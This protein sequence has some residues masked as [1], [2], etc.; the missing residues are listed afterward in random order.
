MVK[1]YVAGLAA[2]LILAMPARAATVAVGPQYGSTHV[3]VAPDRLDAFVTSFI[4][5]FGGHASK[6]AT[7]TVTPAP[8][9]AV[10]RFVATPIGLL[11]VFAYTTPIPYP[12]GEERTGY[13]VTDMDAAVTAAREAGAE[14][15]VA[16]FAD[17]I[18]RDAIIRWPG[19]VEMQLYWHTTAPSA[20]PLAA[21]PDNRVYVSPDRADVFVRDFAQFSG[22][23][24]TDDDHAAPGVEIG[25]PAETYRRIRLTSAFGDMT[26][27]VTEG[28]LPWPYGREVTGYQAA[29]LSATLSK[30][31]A[32]GVDILAGPYSGGGRDAAMVR[33][34]GGYIAEIH[35][36]R[37]R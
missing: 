34:P 4:A 8:S 14:I 21:V 10:G 6:P 33:F 32:A 3:Y 27:L 18:G 11:S 17:A 16:P 1:R 28:H 9:S 24:V 36:V 15:V 12:F 37:P 20:P 2:V 13:L 25:R 5:T 19:G 22:G 7:I 23:H 26:V 30:A 31:R 35:A 29:D